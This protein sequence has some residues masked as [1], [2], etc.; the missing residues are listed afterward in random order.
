MIW[1]ISSPTRKLQISRFVPEKT[2]LSG[3][4]KVLFSKVLLISNCRR[5]PLSLFESYRLTSTS[6]KLYL[7]LNTARRTILNV[8]LYLWYKVNDLAG[9]F[10]LLLLPHVRTAIG[11]QIPGWYFSTA[12]RFLEVTCNLEEGLEWLLC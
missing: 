10:C 7:A 4:F 11:H 3:K 5:T 9:A 8:H 2:S 12:P 1:K 6:F